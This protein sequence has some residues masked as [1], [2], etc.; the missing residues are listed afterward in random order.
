MLRRTFLSTAALAP[1]AS[2]GP[3]IDRKATVSRHNPLLRDFA[4]LSPLS[5]GNG[6]F[7][8][9][10]DLTGLQT[11]PE[12]YENAIPLCT[13]SQW[14]WHTSPL[15]SGLD[16]AAF[17]MTPFDTYG[18]A[19]GYPAG[20][21]GQKD[22]YDW[23]RENPHRLNLGR[24]G[25]HL[26]R[27][28]ISETE[29]RLDLW[30]GILVSRFRAKGSAIEV[31]T[32]CHPSE[33]TLAVEV[34]SPNGQIPDIL[35][36]F[37][38]GSPS[39][40]ASDWTHPD[41]HSTEAG[42]AGRNHV[43]LIRKL[44]R[45][46]H[47]VS[48]AW[49]G[50]AALTREN[51]HRFVLRPAGARLELGIR[52]SLTPVATPP[53]LDAFRASET[54]WSNFWTRGGAIDLSASADSRAR[55]LERR[56]VLSQYLTAIQCSG[57]LPPQETGLTCNSWYGKFHLEMHWWHAAHFALWDRLPLLERSLDYYARILPR[58]RHTAAQQGYAGARWPKMTDPSGRESPSP[59]GPLL[60]WQQPH[61][62]YF[63]E[64]VHRAKP[65]RE[66]L[67]RYQQIVDQTAAFCASYAHHD[68]A[69][70]RYVL[71]PPLIPAQENH[72]PEDTWNPA[73][74]LAYWSWA[75]ATAQR[76]RERL[77][78]K[79]DPKWDDIRAKLSKFPIRDG[80]YLAHENCPETFT[81]KNTDHPSMLAALGVLPG[82]GID[83][84]TMRRTLK[85]VL[86]E[87]RW[88]TTWGWDYPMAAMTAARL[89]E[90]AMAI[91][92]LLLEAPKNRYLP[93][94]HNWQRDTLP[95]Y[96]PGNGGLL[97]ATAMMAAGWDNGPSE[98]APGFPGDW[99]VRVEGIRRMI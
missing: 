20:A 3:A 92:L 12:I 6:E 37:P 33:D 65:G 97:M 16:P 81:E 56:I 18:R 89:G 47:Y 48:V 30:T 1:L 74:E 7:A 39:M 5:A 96:L 73:Y 38:Y 53:S 32:C 15:P 58:A 93:N 76:W 64:L 24:V 45:D 14:G 69:R 13:Q 26:R 9:T 61:I 88:P 57:S 11:C 59:I 83:R 23:L 63:A 31:R 82:E 54:H 8:F 94:G 4:P 70:D 29:Q 90:A 95:L 55:E 49:N 60:I 28:E 80:V 21:T 77:G 51:R 98:P 91:D 87:W 40:S 66:T 19:A 22:L 25:F 84:E 42:Q 44:D 71:G 68:A 85:K 50:D 99:N 35:L 46:T 86:A 62:V 67:E 78:S 41:A 10:A 75:L 2:A 27:S 17:R 43:R 34:S 52:F 79:R 36:E 72:R